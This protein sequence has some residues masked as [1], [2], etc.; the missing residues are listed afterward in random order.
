MELT[1]DIIGTNPKYPKIVNHGALEVDINTY[2]NYPSDNN[3]VRV[4]PK[5]SEMWAHGNKNIHL[6]PNVSVQPLGV[7]NA[8]DGASSDVVREAKKAMMSGLKGREVA[9]HLRSRFAA[10]DIQSA[11]DDLSKLAGE[12]GLLGN[13]YI[14]ASAFK[15]FREA[16]QFLNQHRN[17]LARDIVV[18]EGS[19]TPEVVSLLASR[20]HKNVVSS[21]DYNRDLF[22]NYKMHLVDSGKISNDYVIDSKEALRLAFLSEKE[23]P[24]EAVKK[25]IK[26]VPQEVV[27]EE[28][29]K[30]AEGRS[31]EARIARDEMIIGKIRPILEFVQAQF[32]K[33]TDRPLEG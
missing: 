1:S 33:G 13:V 9:D 5:L 15:S 19:M 32:S 26:A 30:L 18:N 6:V 8:E 11:K 4:L 16:E 14:D 20:F 10:K 12:Q 31:K 7:R 29:G 17:R 2:D 21:L 22:D 3:P 27:N 25:E 24:K 28:L 23:Q